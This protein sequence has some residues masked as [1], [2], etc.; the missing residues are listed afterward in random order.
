M[1]RA[2]LALVL[3]LGACA[4]DPLPPSGQQECAP[5][6]TKRCPSGYQCLASGGRELCWK[7]G[8]TPTAPPPDGDLPDLGG[9]DQVQGSLPDASPD[10]TGDAPSGEVASFEVQPDAPDAAVDTNPSPPDAPPDTTPP[11][12][13][14][15]VAPDLGPVKP[16][17]SG[18]YEDCDGKLENGCEVNLQGDPRNCGKCGMVC[19]LGTG[20]LA[21][22]CTSGTCGMA[23]CSP[24]LMNCD[25]MAA[26]GCESDTSSDVKN[27]GA[28][29]SGC[30]APAQGTAGCGQ[31]MC[32]VA[33]C[34]GAFRDCNLSFADGCEV[35]TA[36][37]LQH[38][39]ACN[40]ACQSRPNSTA[41][42]GPGG[43][44]IAC[45]APFDNCDGDKVNGCESNLTSSKTHCGSCSK[46]CDD[47]PNAAGVCS[48][49]NCVVSCSSGFKDCNGQYQD[50]CEIDARS[51]LQHCGACNAPCAAPNGTVAAVTCASSSCQIV[52]CNPSLGN[53]DGNFGNG[54]EANLNSDVNHCGDCGTAC[55]AGFVCQGTCKWT[56]KALGSRLVL[57]LD[58]AVGVTTSAGKVTNWSDQSGMG[59][60]AAQASSTNQPAVESNAFGSRPAVKF[61]PVDTDHQFLVIPDATSLQFGTGEFTVLVVARASKNDEMYSHFLSKQD[62]FAPYAGPSLWLNQPNAPVDGRVMFQVAFN[63]TGEASI[64]ASYDTNVPF[65]LT[66]RRIGLN[67]IRVRVNGAEFDGTLGVDNPSR[68]VSAVGRPM[69][70][71][72][73][74]TLDGQN[75]RASI[76]EIIAIKGSVSAS[77]LSGLE[78]YLEAKYVG[79][80]F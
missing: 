37:N 35:N 50:G 2:W 72:G 63:Q 39:G 36:T 30:A 73:H 43:C 27:C 57:W 33:S 60:N 74:L 12:L 75:V 8:E 20:G 26:N 56:P 42:C 32:K 23:A 34:M 18:G 10:L 4:Y 53:C 80:T 11:D 59:N 66:G 1:K 61:N 15:D 55:S 48:N 7:N 69:T 76:G 62:A 49:S 58:A 64:G 16:V 67:T 31:G 46:S 13:A 21:A 65:I 29:G 54:C 70:I 51:N 3:V 6:G 22:V 38:C 19:P 79:L 44:D 14:P 68:D 78:T 28:C 77:D 9:P 24:P 71:G 40:N 47:P 45:T 5:A 41:V 17:C 25:G 52:T